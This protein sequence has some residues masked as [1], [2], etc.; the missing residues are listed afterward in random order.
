V[1]KVQCCETRKGTLQQLCRELRHATDKK[2]EKI[3]T[4]LNGHEW[5]ISEKMLKKFLS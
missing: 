5:D 2:E 4:I 3:W 1:E